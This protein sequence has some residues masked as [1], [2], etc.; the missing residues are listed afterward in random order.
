MPDSV[1][2]RFKGKTVLI[3]GGMGFI[4]ASLAVRLAQAGADVLVVD[5]MLEPY[6]ANL[7][8]IEPVKAMVTVNFCDIRDQNAMDYLVTG[9]EYVFHCAAQVCHL[10]SLDNPFI[11]IDINIK[12]AA[13]LMEAL[14]KRN[15]DAVVVKMGS[16]G[17][18][19]SVQ[20]L[21][22]GED[23]LPDPKGIYEISLLSAEQI[24]RSYYKI[25]GIK[26]VMLR[27]TNIY[28]PRGQMKHNRFGVA[29][30]FMRLALDGIKIPIYG[31]GSIQR[32]FLYIDD[33]VEA[34]L[35]AAL[36]PEM[37]GEVYNVG[38]DDPSSFLELAQVIVEKLGK[39]GWELTP[40]SNERKAQEPGHFYS[41]ISKIK[42]ACGWVPS[43]SLQ[44]GVA[45]SLDYYKAN[46][47][48]YW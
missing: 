31:D 40:F 47:D 21:P 30:W 28:G 35:L 5:N 25:H 33:C 41:D 24:M 18:Y 42:K 37:A 10:M 20:K 8:N 22:A 14:K 34:I 4:G 27:L 32:D 13:V 36:N 16:R 44:D 46:K 38:R 48:K 7:F 43:T 19:G 15:R 26:S 9:R 6:G 23:V 11:D 39:G 3:T 1:A 17:Q 12:G 2:A 45:A 29:N